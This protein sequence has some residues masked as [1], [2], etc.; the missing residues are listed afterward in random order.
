M[1]AINKVNLKE[2]QFG[3]SSLWSVR[4]KKIDGK[5]ILANAKPCAMCREIAVKKGFR[6][7]Y[8]S[9]DN[10][11]IQKE[12]LITMK[13]NYTTASLIN[14]RDNLHFSNVNFKKKCNIS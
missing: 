1:D 12:N 4:W 7:V 6:H 10:G 3:R 11:N 8:Y 9:D 13:S 2:R 5:Y 14:M